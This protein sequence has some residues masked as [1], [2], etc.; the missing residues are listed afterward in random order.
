M[1]AILLVSL[2]LSSCES[3]QKFSQI[4]D[5]M[6]KKKKNHNDGENVFIKLYFFLVKNGLPLKSFLPVAWLNGLF[7]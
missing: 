1:S 6:G 5:E 2:L 7:L 3:V 4:P